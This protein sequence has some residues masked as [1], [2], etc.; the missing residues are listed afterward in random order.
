MGVA[1]RRARE[2]QQRRDEILDAAKKIFSAKGFHGAT[3]E[4]IAGEAELSPATLYLY[5]SNKNE[6]YTSLNVRMLACLCRRVEQ[7]A[8]EK[9]VEPIEKV[10]RLAS[11]MY[12]VYAYDPINLINVLHMQAS[13]D[14]A[15]LS[16]ELQEQ[17][18][19]MATRALRTIA[20]IFSE[21]MDS[22]QFRRQPPMALADTTWAV[23]SGLVLWEE[24]KR[25]FAPRKDFLKNTLELAIDNLAR[26]ISQR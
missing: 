21:G 3:I 9:G 16:P 17:I 24:S 12:D 8:G 25:V 26:G 6:L 11:A 15:E 5:F 2:K 22:G 23:F 13:Q 18:N 14:L 7:V 10:R 4:E 20:S 19:H 1:E